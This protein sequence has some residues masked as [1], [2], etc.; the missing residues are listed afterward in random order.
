M[1]SLIQWTLGTNASSSHHTVH[2]NLPELLQTSNSNNNT[3]ITKYQ[4]EM[5]EGRRRKKENKKTLSSHIMI[6]ESLFHLF[7]CFFMRNGKDMCI[8]I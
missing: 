6:L 3:I 4:K 8:V 1:F 5:N 2:A 7:E